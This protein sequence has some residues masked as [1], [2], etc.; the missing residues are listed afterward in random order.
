VGVGGI[1]IGLLVGGMVEIGG[2][3]RKYLCG[4]VCGFQ[5]EFI[6]PQQQ[7]SFSK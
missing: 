5:T 1:Y 7:H 4:A 2:T 6:S 3:K